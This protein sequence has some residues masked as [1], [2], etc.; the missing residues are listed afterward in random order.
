MS[1]AIKPAAIKRVCNESHALTR[2]LERYGLALTRYEIRHIGELIAAGESDNVKLLKP[3]ADHEHRTWAA[4]RVEGR[5]VPFVYD[6]ATS[7]VVTCLPEY[8]LDGYGLTGIAVVVASQPP[9]EEATHPVEILK[10]LKLRLAITAAVRTVQDA[11]DRREGLGAILVNLHKC[12]GD[13][14]EW[15]RPTT[16]FPTKAEWAAWHEDAKAASQAATVECSRLRKVFRESCK[17]ISE[18]H[19]SALIGDVNDP[20]D[21]LVAARAY[22]VLPDRGDTWEARKTIATAICYYLERNWPVDKPAVP[23]TKADT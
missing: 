7:S 12:L 17:A 22:L 1:G 15:R 11:R 21:L 10:A 6:A 5:W 9:A 23:A 3:D 14:G 20:L 16:V 18:R 2:A 19:T 4:V 8:V 13:Y